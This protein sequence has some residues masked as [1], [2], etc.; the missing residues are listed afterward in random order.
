MQSS[1][2]FSHCL[3]FLSIQPA[4]ESNNT[5][6]VKVLTQNPSKNESSF[7]RS[8]LSEQY[9]KSVIKTSDWCVY[10]EEKI[11]NE[12]DANAEIEIPLHVARSTIPTESFYSPVTNSKKYRSKCAG[13]DS[14][15]MKPEA[16]KENLDKFNSP[17][18]AM[19][20]INR[21][22]KIVDNEYIS[23]GTM[24]YC[25]NRIKYLR[26]IFEEDGYYDAMK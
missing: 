1:Q 11:N 3:L 24:A 23:D 6:T 25:I 21:L 14:E 16:A 10:E 18:K 12:I 15:E 26:I 7:I 13:L 17:E 19:A 4:E 2:H 9:Q 22:T 20:E 5:S 8:A